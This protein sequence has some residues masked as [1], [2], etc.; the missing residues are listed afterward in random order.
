M[1][2]GGS[3]KPTPQ[4]DMGNVATSEV[5]TNQQAISIPVVFGTNKVALAWISPALN[6]FTR[7]APTSR[8]GKK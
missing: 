5:S 6:Q 1:S 8:P 2:F 3:K 4:P 7:P